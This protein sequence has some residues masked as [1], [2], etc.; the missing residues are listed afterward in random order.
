MGAQEH[1]LGLDRLI[2]NMFKA[3]AAR[4]LRVSCSVLRLHVVAGFKTMGSTCLVSASFAL[5]PG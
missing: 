4:C 5:R 3:I 1:A 2:K